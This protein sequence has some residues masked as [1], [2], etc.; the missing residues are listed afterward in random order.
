MDSGVVIASY[1]FLSEMVVRLGLGIATGKGHAAMI[2]QRFGKWWGW[3]SLIDL[4]LVNFLALVTEFA[5]ISL[6]F[7][8]MGVSPTISVP[9]SALFLTLIVTSGSYLRWGRIVVFLCVLDIIWIYLLFHAHPDGVEAVKNFVPIIHQG[10]IT[11]DMVFMVIAVVGTT[12]APWQLFFQQS[13][14]ADKKL[15]FKD[16]KWARPD[17]FIGA[18]FKVIM[19]PELFK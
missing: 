14:I 2:Y 1:L 12:I 3:F 9:V 6:A 10:S 11:S 15:R 19:L 7:S 18:V 13:I 17:T 8:K 4:E 16:L 5:A